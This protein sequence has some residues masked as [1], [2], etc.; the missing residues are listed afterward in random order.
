MKLQRIR[1]ELKDK[2][3]IAIAEKYSCI[4]RRYTVTLTSKTI[5]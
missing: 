2:N 1:N 5:Y 4:A 3:E